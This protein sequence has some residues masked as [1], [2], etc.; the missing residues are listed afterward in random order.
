MRKLAQTSTAL[1]LTGVASTAMA[2][3]V[4]SSFGDARLYWRLSFDESAKRVAESNY[5]FVVDYDR[6]FGDAP[7]VPAAQVNFD[8]R[9]LMSAW[10]NG[11]PFARRM[12]MMQTEGEGEAA[13]AS[14]YTAVDYG[15]LALGAVGIGYGISTVVD[16]KDTSDPASGGGS[17]TN[18]SPTTGPCAGLLCPVT[19]PLSPVLG[20]LSPVTGPLSPVLGP[21]S[22]ITGP[23]GGFTAGATSS[24]EERAV[25]PEYQQWLDDGMGGMG[26]LVVIT[27]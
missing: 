24:F 11:V 27:K 20:P 4:S 1:L 12:T 25:T 14:S 9:G 16:Q 22:P 13:S 6:R 19:G 15:L 21:L 18:G 7:P 8:R 10:L 3:G 17:P 26:D 23:L 2:A 5:S